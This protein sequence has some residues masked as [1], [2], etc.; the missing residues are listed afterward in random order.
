MYGYFKKKRRKRHETKIIL[1]ES[2]QITVTYIQVSV[3]YMYGFFTA[4]AFG[5]QYLGSVIINV[6]TG[7]HVSYSLL[8]L[9]KIQRSVWLVGNLYLC[10]CTK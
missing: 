6:I 1:H 3:L 9:I 5:K 8:S 10:M 2:I 4:V 7:R